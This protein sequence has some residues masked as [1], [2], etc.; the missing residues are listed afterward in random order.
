MAN[1]ENTSPATYY[2]NIVNEITNIQNLEKRLLTE[3]AHGSSSEDLPN[4]LLFN[5]T[6]QCGNYNNK[7][8]TSVKTAEDNNISV[9]K[10]DG[11]KTSSAQTD[12]MVFSKAQ[13]GQ[14]VGEVVG[15]MPV[16]A[17]GDSVDN[18]T[19]RRLPLGA[20]NVDGDVLEIEDNWNAT[21]K[22]GGN[23]VAWLSKDRFTI[24]FNYKNND[25]YGFTLCTKHVNPD[26]YENTVKSKTDVINNISDLTDLRIKLYKN[27]QVNL[28]TY[29]SQ[30]NNS[31][32][33]LQDQL[34]TVGIVEDQL[35]G[36][37]DIL[38]KLQDA[39]ED[40]M[41]M[42][43]IGTY[44]FQRY[45]AHKRVMY[46]IILTCLAI[47][48]FSIMTQFPIIPSAVSTFGITISLAVGL[49][50]LF[51]NI[52]DLM[53]RSNSNYQQYDFDFDTD[54]YKD[55]NY[56]TVIEYDRQA[57]SHLLDD[58]KETGDNISSHIKHAD[59]SKIDPTKLPHPKST[60]LETL[61]LNIS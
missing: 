57:L 54:K 46:I 47:L 44:E 27:L 4:I 59:L 6:K 25:P 56:Q 40:K 10:L 9:C 34:T 41:R 26:E 35:N 55:P 14:G 7:Q 43:E 18:V 20:S 61:K 8:I 11:D 39:K 17:I 48:A 51:W 21:C 29:Q 52:W 23:A 1:N 49:I 60:S 42:I 28:G 31:R 24:P 58:M 19:I 5:G 37:K 45:N 12:I 33:S 2:Q 36:T 32:V 16:E 3:L 30:M 50:V 15:D 53:L 22:N 38:Q 13:A